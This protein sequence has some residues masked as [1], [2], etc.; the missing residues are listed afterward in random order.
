MSGSFIVSTISA[1]SFAT[2]V[3]VH[4]ANLKTDTIGKYA[5]EELQMLDRVAC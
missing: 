2:Q 5:N 1:R 3:T 4:A